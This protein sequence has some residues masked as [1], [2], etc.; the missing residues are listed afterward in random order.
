MKGKIAHSPFFSLRV[1]SSV[2]PRFAVVISKKVA[3]KA[4]DRNLIKRRTMAIAEGF[5]KAHSS[6][7]SSVILFAKKGAADLGFADHKKEI[8]NLISSVGTR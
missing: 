2:K 5:L 4:V 3:A 8:L 6:F 7:S 1:V